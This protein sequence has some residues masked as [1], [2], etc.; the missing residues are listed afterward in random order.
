MGGGEG[1]EE[2][3]VRELEINMN[4]PLYLKRVMNKDLAYST[5]ELC[6]MLC[7]SLDGRGVWGRMAT[8]ICMT[9]SLRC[10]PET[11]LLQH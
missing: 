1:W 9:E 5:G 3:V 6:S 7:G 10:S 2:G 4:T 8:Y 11:I